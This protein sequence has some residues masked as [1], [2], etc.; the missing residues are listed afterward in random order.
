[1]IITATM[2]AIVAI[3]IYLADC[4]VLVERGQG[5]FEFGCPSPSASFGS[6]HYVLRKRPVVLLNP[7]TP[8]R[9]SIKSES[10]FRDGLTTSGTSIRQT[11]RLQPIAILGT[12]QAVLIFVAVPLLLHF[13]PGWPFM[14]SV[15]IAMLVSAAIAA[16]LWPLRAAMNLTTLAYINT[17]VSGV[18]C[19]PLS[20]NIAR[21]APLA[22]H[23]SFTA[24]RLLR[25]LPPLHR[26]AARDE[27]IAQ[28]EEACLETDDQSAKWLQLRKT[29]TELVRK[30]SNVRP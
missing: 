22:S 25:L 15:A 16:M 19:L 23:A 21:K 18:I 10:V 3:L 20:V 17:A 29:L 28:L 6:R 8:W 7:L 4:V 24:P 12:I 13:E 1:V 9:L 14:V 27:F 26:E 2:V 30:N 11:R 5:I